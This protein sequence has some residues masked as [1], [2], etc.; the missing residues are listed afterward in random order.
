MADERAE[1]EDVD[2]P[3]AYDLLG[4]VRV[5]APGVVR[6]RDAFHRHRDYEGQTPVEA[7]REKVD[8]ASHNTNRDPVIPGTPVGL[9][10][11][12]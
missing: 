3:V 12:R 7:E 6:L 9:T 11:S 5:A 8:V 1:V 10:N 2:G 4:D